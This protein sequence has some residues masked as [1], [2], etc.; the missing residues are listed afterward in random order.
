[1]SKSQQ[2]DVLRAC[3]EE[4]VANPNDFAMLDD[5]EIEELCKGMKNLVGKKFKEAVA[6][7]KVVRKFTPP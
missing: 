4:G 3:D 2:N 5:G 1:M 6:T 7:T